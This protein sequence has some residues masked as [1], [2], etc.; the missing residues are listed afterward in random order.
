MLIRQ[1]EELEKEQKNIVEKILQECSEVKVAY[2]L[3]QLFFQ[4]FRDRRPEQL[5]S[6]L[7]KASSSTLPEF[8]NFAKGIK[9]DLDAINAALNFEWSNGQTEG[10]VNRL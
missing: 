1:S 9:Y 4:M 2:D 10:Q 7:L 8:R 5:N 6:W 3:T